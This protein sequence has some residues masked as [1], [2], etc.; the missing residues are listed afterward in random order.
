MNTNRLAILLVL[1]LIVQ[2]AVD[3]R[4]QNNT[5]PI[6][7]PATINVDSADPTLSVEKV[8][9]GLV[10]AIGA[11][12][13]F[14]YIPTQLRDSLL[15]SDSLGQPPT[16]ADAASRLNASIVCFVQVRRFMNLIRSEVTFVEDRDFTKSRSGVGL[17]SIRYADGKN[18]PVADP[19]ILASIQRAL[20]NVLQDG[21]VYSDLDSGLNVRPASVIVPGGIKFTSYAAEGSQWELFKAPPVVSYDIVQTVV[22]A[23]QDHQDVIVVDVETRDSMYATGGLY[24]IENNKPLANTELRILRLFEVD[25]AISGSFKQLMNKAVLELQLLAIQEDGSYRTLKASLK[26]VDNDT[27]SDLRGM[28]VEALEELLPTV[29][30]GN[31]E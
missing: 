23:L 31:E 5:L 15:L 10:L 24:L 30:P 4:G 18:A 8:E 12:R 3:A 26:D 16:V 11:S 19:A 13:M 28:V 14:R 29:P 17:A 6:I 21:S 2:G 27:T 25:L 22:H 7:M 20:M 1:T 9:A